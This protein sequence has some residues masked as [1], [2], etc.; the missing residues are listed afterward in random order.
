[1]VALPL[2]LGGAYRY[3]PDME[4]INRGVFESE[5]GGKLSRGI[6]NTAWG[7]TEMVITPVNMG[8]DPR[9]G[10][11]SALVLGVPYGVFRAIGRTLVGVYEV[12]TCYAPQKP[13]FKPI[14]G[15]VV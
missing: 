12:S 9:H 3:P 13:I 4:N 15:E 10:I 14:E 7:W 2:W 1:M 11:M 8:G 6:A 5:I